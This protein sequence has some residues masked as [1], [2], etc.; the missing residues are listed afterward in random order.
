MSVWLLPMRYIAA[1]VVAGF[2]FPRLE[3]AYLDRAHAMSVSVAIAFFS[4]VASGMMALAG[5]VFAIAFVVVQFGALAYSPRLTEAY[6]GSRR[7]YHVLG[8]FFATFTYALETLAWT[9]RENSGTVPFY[10]TMIVG[11]LLLASMLAFARLIQS[12][13]D[14]KVHN[15]LRSLGGRGREVI[16]SMFP[17]PTNRRA[18][19]TLPPCP[20]LAR[21]DQ[22][23]TY[24]GEPLTITRI[25]T[26]ALIRLATDAGAV[27]AFECGVGETL[28]D[29]TVIMRVHGAASPIPEPA[30]MR[31][32]TSATTRTFEQDPKY[33]IRLLVDIAHPGA[34]AGDQRSD[35]RG[36]GIDQI[37]GLLRRSG[38]A[39]SR[40][41]TSAMRP[42]RSG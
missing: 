7:Q 33:A 16:D 23:V 2:I 6:A 14:L 19:A 10:S 21:P 3:D 41:R 28:F 9:D 15:V 35:H 11:V 32:S 1:S 40:R 22:P 34:V 17:L 39:S 13:D 37:E 24:S 12:L 29:D 4:T 31:P 25:D 18:S 42:G 5:I 38:G 20:A 26:A 36:A 8:I 30:L 27:V